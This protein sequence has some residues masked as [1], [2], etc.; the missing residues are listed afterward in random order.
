MSSLKKLNR[1]LKEKSENMAKRRGDEYNAF[2]FSQMGGPNANLTD[3]ERR[4]CNMYLFGAM[5]DRMTI[6]DL[7]RLP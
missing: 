7:E 5:W 4:S 3:A 6:A 1:L 2:L